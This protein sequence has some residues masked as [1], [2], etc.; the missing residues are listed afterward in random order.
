MI[1]GVDLIYAIIFS[2]YIFKYIIYHII[3]PVKFVSHRALCKVFIFLETKATGLTILL[4]SQV[5]RRKHTQECMYQ[6][7]LELLPH[8]G[9]GPREKASDLNVCPL[10]R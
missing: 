9:F 3:F 8:A 7:N 4:N 2:S 10:G 6:E 1:G 5:E